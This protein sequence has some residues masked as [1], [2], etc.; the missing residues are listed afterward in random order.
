MKLTQS[1]GAQPEPPA[2]LSQTGTFSNMATLQPVS[3]LLPYDVN[4][5]LYSDGADK[6][7]WFAIPNDGAHNSPGEKIGFTENGNWTFPAGSVLVKHFDM[8]IDEQNPALIRRME[9]RFMVQG[10]N[11]EYFGFTYRWRPDGSDADLLTGAMNETV[12]V[13]KADGSIVNQAWHY[14]SRTECF[15][16][17]STASGY[18]LG[19]RTRQ[20]NGDYTYSKTGRTEN[21]LETL[22]HLG[23][24]SPSINP[25]LLPDVLTSKPMGDNS[26]SLQKRALSYIDSNCS[27]CHQPGGTAHT[28]FDAR[29]STSPFSQGIVNVAPNNSL[30]I[31]G[32]RIVAPRDTSRSVL[33]HRVNSLGFGAMPPLAKN[34][35]DDG[36]IA[37]LQAWIATIDPNVTPSSPSTSDVTPPVAT[38]TAP[39]QA[40]GNFTVNVAFSETVYGL[41]TDDFAI[42][43]GAAV[44]LSGSGASY[45]LSVA[46]AGAASVTVT[47]PTDSVIDAGSNANPPS[48]SVTSAVASLPTVHVSD[49]AADESAGAIHF[50]VAL[51]AAAT[52]AV[53]V[54]YA[55]QPGTATAPEDYQ[56][57]SGTLTIPAGTVTATLSVPL[58]DDSIHESAETLTIQLSSPTGATLAASTAAGTISDNDAMPQISIMDAVESEGA[59]VAPFTL[60]LSHPSSL[61]VAVYYQTVSGSA[62]AGEDFEYSGST[63]WFEPGQTS[64]NLS[65]PVMNDTI[66]ELDETFAVQL[67]L[68]QNGTIADAEGIATIIDDDTTPV[69]SISGGSASESA[70]TVDFR[71]QLSVASGAVVEV[72]YETVSRSAVEGSD[73]T[74]STG[75]LSISAGVTEVT[76]PIAVT[77][78]GFNEPDEEFSVN[79]SA[80]KNAVLGESSAVGVILDDDVVSLSV[81]STEADETAGSMQFAVTLSAA[82]HGSVFVNYSTAPG[83]AVAPDDF[84]AV[85][86]TLTIPAGQTSGTIG[87]SIV[88]DDVFEGNETYTVTLSE[89]V[90]ASIGFATAT[91]TIIDDDPVPDITIGNAAASELSGW[92]DFPVTLSAPSNGAV[93]FSY[94]TAGGSADSGVDFTAETGTLTIAAGLSAATVRVPL[95]DDQII[96]Q[97]ESFTLTVSEPQNGT[98][99]TT[100]A[101]AT[102]LDDEAGAQISINAAEADEGGTFEFGLLLSGPS[103]QVVSVD[104][105]LIPGT[106]TAEQDFTV[107]SGTLTFAA[108]QQSITLRVNSLEDSIS[109]ATETFSVVLSNPEN[110]TLAV[111]SVDGSIVDNDEEPEVTVKPATA[112]ES[113]GAMPF[114]FNLSGLSSREVTTFYEVRSGTADAA[115]FEAR[116]GALHFPPGKTSAILSIPV[117]DDQIDEPTETMVLAVT[118]GTYAQVVPTEI[119]GTILDNDEPP[120]IEI[121]SSSA[122]ESEDEITFQITLSGRSG[123]DVSVDWSAGAGSATAGS[124][125]NAASGTVQIPAGGLGTTVSV[126]LVADLLP[127][128]NE[129]LI[130]S[131]SNPQ[132]ASLGSASA[133]G[134]ILDDD[135]PPS[136]SVAGE[137][138]VYEGEG[139]LVVE[140]VATEPHTAAMTVHVAVTTGVAESGVDFSPYSKT[141]VFDPGVTRVPVSVAIHDDT[142]D[143]SIESVVITLSSPTNAT[144][145]TARAIGHI[146]DNDQAPIVAIGDA[147]ALESG[148]LISFPVT[149]SAASAKPVAVSWQ[150]SSGSATVG[151]DFSDSQGTLHIPMGG[152]RV[153]IP[154][155]LL[156]DRVYEG[157][158]NFTI[159]LSTPEFA[160]LGRSSAVATVHDDETV[161]RLAIDSSLVS[162]KSGTVAFTI[163]ASNAS[164]EQIDVSYATATDTADEMD[165]TTASGSVTLLPGETSAVVE[166]AITDDIVDEPNESFGLILTNPQQA[167]IDI[168]RGDCTILDDDEPPGISVADATGSEQD[169]EL[170]FPVTLST[171][172]GF[173]VGVSYSVAG[174]TAVVGE[175]FAAASGTVTF[176]PGITSAAIR[177]PILDDVSDEHA[178]TLSVELSDPQRGLIKSGIATGTIE[179]NDAAPEISI[180]N[181]RAFESARSMAFRVS[182]SEPSAKNIAMDCL[183]RAGTADEG[184]D[185]LPEDGPISIPAGA[186]GALIVI[187]LI[188]D[189][190]NEDDET[191]EVVLSNAV[192]ASIVEGV[193][194]GLILNDD[195]EPR[196]SIGN[197]S[198]NE[199]AGA[200]DFAL[201]L[202]AP[203]GKAVEVEFA[204]SN[205]TATVG[206][207]FKASTGTIVFSPGTTQRTVTIPLIDDEI[208]EKPEQFLVNLTG[209]TNADIDDGKGI[210]FIADNDARNTE[211]ARRRALDAYAKGQLS[212]FADPTS[213]E[214]FLEYVVPYIPELDGFEV[215]PQVSSNLIDW[216]QPTSGDLVIQRNGDHVRGL[217]RLSGSLRGRYLRFLLFDRPAGD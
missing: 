134:T 116:T 152:T 113:D 128:L 26:A 159:E 208:S 115:D 27:H 166:I 68:P 164:T 78:D 142:L 76:I 162:E 53:T 39:P 118:G 5:P 111:S 57:T 4:T 190:L 29:L 33:Y 98:L 168:A 212:R 48:N 130:L 192:N 2:L 95:L 52:S 145:G 151:V 172:S 10:S 101:T 129:T 216:V 203:S 36:A 90:N 9:T 43:N 7:R 103:A 182:L 136:L 165:Y 41:S 197:A 112:I 38:L 110:A 215:V 146:F 210:G 51:S 123:F 209:A 194:A 32:A 143:E 25:A 161:P 193:G 30:G 175:D 184:V 46:A 122:S 23:I 35:V 34:H 75:T 196:V 11:G 89:A 56:H 84:Q 191:F 49:A 70:G 189:E 96:E 158:E 186:T 127:E 61:P 16:C 54:Q 126:P 42:S 91:G 64:I 214:R 62:V 15:S 201:S 102:I 109:E 204:A 79:I 144:L 141:I 121:A 163:S 73:Y 87:V 1:H 150:V 169:G 177:V 13:R 133:T 106:A 59:F 72:N 71:V 148:N 176:A 188:S 85:S 28:N 58:I 137:A 69:L 108:Q 171:A 18:V 55:T 213:G 105:T 24:F 40:S 174:D 17:H 114:E 131:L 22:N 83:T 138:S 199:S 99:L 77:D 74:P 8:P 154:V 44:G 147:L 3:G 107:S 149:L 170:V 37:L 211:G 180:E 14:P 86:G 21:Q 20:L 119:V 80:P 81:A 207:D 206:E 153:D 156:D 47:L 124:D 139:D 183:T 173:T 117:T 50:G 88:D 132:N 97:N 6:K 135:A 67:S 195:A 202:S 82:S 93:G 65:I 187:P 104:Y 217:M 200:I 12:P 157:T 100:S 45:S 120:A 205:I 125:F 167:T 140:I 198:T 19:P 31:S 94:A 181:V 155:P 160:E 63:L 92:V 178:E 60:H 66:D 179:D 185:Y